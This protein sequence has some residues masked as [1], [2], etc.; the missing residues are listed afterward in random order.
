[1]ERVLAI[2][3]SDSAVHE[4]LLAQ[5]GEL[6]AGVGADVLAL[7]VV[8]EDEFTGS[9]QRKASVGGGRSADDVTEQ[10]RATAETV[11]ASV[12]E[13]T[14]VDYEP[15]GLVGKIPDDIVAFADEHDCDHVFVVGRH[16]S[17]T[18][19]AVFGDIAQSVVLNFDGPVTVLTD[20]D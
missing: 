12:L 7:T 16:R 15:A 9:I 18:G 4:R 17:P 11:A 8:D 2:V 20:D 1:M 3:D 13:S 10:A 6:A 5:A 14:D 19:K